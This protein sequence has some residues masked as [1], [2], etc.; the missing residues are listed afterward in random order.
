[1]SSKNVKFFKTDIT[2]LAQVASAVTN[3]V[4]WASTTS[5]PLGGV[6]NCA[7]VGTAAKIIDA[8]GKPHSLDIWEFAI[9]VNLTGSFNLT[10]LV[11]EH[12]VKVQPEAGRDGERGVVVFVASAAA[13]GSFNQCSRVG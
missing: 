12:L 9:A 8:H 5:A 7:G 4:E 3:T 2:V 10:R 13:V 6:I 11:L 1:M